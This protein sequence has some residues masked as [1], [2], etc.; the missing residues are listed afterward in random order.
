MERMVWG[1]ILERVGAERSGWRPN[2][3]IRVET[4]R[5]WIDELTVYDNNRSE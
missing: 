5:Q 3:W 1:V 4:N 2:E